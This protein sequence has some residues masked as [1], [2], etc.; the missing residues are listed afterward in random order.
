MRPAGLLIP[1]I[2]AAAAAAPV[3]FEVQRERSTIAVRTDK[4]G[5][6]SFAAGHKHGINA[7][8]FSA[9]I[10]ADPANLEQAAV[11]IV[12]PVSA[13]RID[14]PEAR[15]AAGL[16][17][18]D[19]PKASDVQKIQPKML[20][21]LGA[22]EHPQIRFESSSVRQSGAGT[23]VLTGPLTVRGRSTP[24]SVPVAVKQAGGVYTFS[25]K[26]PVRQTVF[27]ITPESIAGVVKVEDPVT[28][29]FS[30]AARPTTA[31]CK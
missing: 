25:G 18:S 30:L 11:S 27:G 1:V 12:V 22:G 5:L 21:R 31:A 2:A 13:L 29:F 9:R 28:V 7:T 10:C 19:G 8:Q 17:P 15:Q 3:S 20:D 6:L 24:V 4:T 16:S 26:F 14:S 23:I